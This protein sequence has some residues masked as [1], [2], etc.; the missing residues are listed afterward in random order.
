FRSWLLI[1]PKEKRLQVFFAIRHTF[2]HLRLFYKLISVI[3]L[4]NR[5][6]QTFART[7]YKH[8]CAYL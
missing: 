2:S 4:Q 8:Q 5:I 6:K 1:Y 3:K 7:T